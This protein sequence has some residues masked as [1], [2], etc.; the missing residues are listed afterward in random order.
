MEFQ[1]KYVVQIPSLRAVTCV[2]PLAFVLPLCEPYY[3]G[4]SPCLPCSDADI[5]L[6]CMIDHIICIL[7]FSHQNSLKLEFSSFPFIF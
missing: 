2:L 6:P 3:L 1:N 5:F 7:Y 4:L